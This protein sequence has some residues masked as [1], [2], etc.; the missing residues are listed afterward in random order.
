MT[1]KQARPRGRADPARYPNKINLRISDAMLADLEGGCD[2][3]DLALSCCCD[4][5]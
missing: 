5:H 2:R 1:G 4:P 3:Y